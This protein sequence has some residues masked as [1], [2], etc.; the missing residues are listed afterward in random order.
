VRLRLLVAMAAV[1]AVLGAAVGVW[2]ARGGD[3]STACPTTTFLAEDSM[4][5]KVMEYHSADC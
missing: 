1:L 2:A 5:P 3:E 4:T